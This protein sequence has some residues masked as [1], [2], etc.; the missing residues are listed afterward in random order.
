MKSIFNLDSPLMQM[1]TRSACRIGI[2]TGFFN[3]KSHSD[4]ICGF[5]DF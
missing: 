3:A 2:V 1:L 4:R 5:R